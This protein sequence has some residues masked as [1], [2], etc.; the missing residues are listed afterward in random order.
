[1]HVF[2][3]FRQLVH[4]GRLRSHCLNG[5]RVDAVENADETRTPSFFVGG[6]VCKLGDA[7]DDSQWLAPWH[8][9]AGRELVT[10]DGWSHGPLDNE[11][12]RQWPFDTRPS[13]TNDT[14]GSVIRSS[15]IQFSADGRMTV[16]TQGRP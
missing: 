12:N 5:Q 8:V 14:G 9:S 16:V 15:P 10:L 4:D 2:F 13:L 1:M 11:G 7:R 3:D 6:N